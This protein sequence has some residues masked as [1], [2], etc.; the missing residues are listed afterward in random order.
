MMR[1]SLPPAL[2]ICLTEYKFISS[3]PLIGFLF[4]PGISLFFSSTI[5]TEE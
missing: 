5:K 4:I 1:Y 3:L 2:L